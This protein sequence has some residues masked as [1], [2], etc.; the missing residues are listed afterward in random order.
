MGAAAQLAGPVADGDDAHPVAVLLAEQRH[1]PRPH[2]V[3]LAH[4]LGVH[5]E[6]VEDDGVDARLHVGHH[7]GRHRPEGGEVEAEPAREFSEPAWVAVSPSS[8]RKALCTMWVAV[9][10]REIARRRSTSTSE[11]AP[12]P[13]VTSPE[14]TTAWWTDEPGDRRLHVADLDAGAVVELDDTLVGELTAAL[15]IERGAVEDQLDHVARTRG[16]DHR[17]VGDETAHGALVD[18]EVVAGELHGTAEGVGD[19]TVGAGVAVLALLGL[20][21]GFGAL[22]LLGHQPAEACLVDGEPARRPSRG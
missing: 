2:G 18:D 11:C 15:G 12:S 13:G 1:R 8:S 21:V 19:L 4:H 17:A 7:R 22:P 14:S 10:E 20:R 3:V 9:W 5:G 16:R 6:V